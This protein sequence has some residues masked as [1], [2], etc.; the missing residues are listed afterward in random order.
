[1]HVIVITVGMLMYC[2]ML[3]SLVTHLQYSINIATE[4]SLRY[5]LT[6]VHGTQWYKNLDDNTNQVTIVYRIYKYTYKA[7][8][9]YT[10]ILLTIAFVLTSSRLFS[11]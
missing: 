11:K 8:Y 9:V 1:M 7:I 4:Q 5:I 3:S 6:Y 2:F 10:F